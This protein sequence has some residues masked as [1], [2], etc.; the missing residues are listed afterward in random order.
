M[1]MFGT[2]HGN[3][4]DVANLPSGERGALSSPQ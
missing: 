1:V 2:R 3:L 4:R